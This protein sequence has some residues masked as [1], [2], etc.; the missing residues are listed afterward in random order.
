M[1]KKLLGLALVVALL[2]PSFSFAATNSYAGV[3]SSILNQLLTLLIQEV[4][5]LEQQLAAEQAQINTITAT[6]TVSGVATTTVAT[7]T[8]ATTTVATSSPIVQQLQTLQQS[9]PTRTA[10]VVTQNTVTNNSSVM[11]VVTSTPDVELTD[12]ERMIV[13]SVNYDNR[14][15][16]DDPTDCPIL[17]NATTSGNIANID[18]FLPISNVTAINGVPYTDSSIPN[19]AYAG[20]KITLTGNFLFAYCIQQTK[21]GLPKNEIYSGQEDDLGPITSTSTFT[22]IVPN[23][24]NVEDLSHNDVGDNTF[25]IPFIGT[26]TPS[27]TQ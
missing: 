11:G 6:S 5:S 12:Q 17:T 2:T 24:I 19:Y 14:E 18:K 10:P 8:I 16:T 1:N 22:F 25:L 27:T 20:E 7:T 13:N 4:Q 3:S 23:D 9:I 26:S 21:V 15:R